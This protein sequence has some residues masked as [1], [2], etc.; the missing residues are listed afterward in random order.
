[1]F[2]GDPSHL[3][4][5][6]LAI[7]D[8]ECRWLERL[9]AAR[10]AEETRRAASGRRGAEALRD[11]LRALRD[12]AMERS[13][14]DLPDVLH[15]LSVRQRLAAQPAQALPDQSV[16][17]L[18]HLAVMQAGRR[19][20]Y[21]LGQ[22]SLFDAERDV[23]MVDWRVAPVAQI[24]YGYKEGEQYEVEYPGRSVE[25]VVAVRRAVVVSQ[26]VLR[27][28]LTEGV[29]L[30]RTEQGAWLREDRDATK[31]ARGGAGNAARPGI[32]GVGVGG[33]HRADVA[34]TALLDAEQYAVVSAA[35]D[36]P[37]LVLGSAGSGKTTV[38]LHRLMW[39]AT[40]KPKRYA[41]ERALVI[42][43]EEGLARLSR[44]LLQP[45]GGKTADVRTL[46]AW[47]EQ[48]CKDV[49]GKSMPP[50]Y[51]DAPG[52]VVNLKR[53]PA[54]YEELRVEFAK[55]RPE[56]TTIRRLR[57]RLVERFSDRA[58]LERVVAR[59][60]GTLA[61]AAIEQ[62]VRH[63]MLQIADT[64]AAE[65]ARITDPRMKVALDGERIEAGTPQEIA[66]TV[67]I[68]DLPIYLFLKAWR[69]K[70]SVA[71]VSQLVIDEA[72]D[73]SLFELF[74]LGRLL[75][76]EA[77]VILAGDEAQQTHSSFVTWQRA[78][79][80]LGSRDARICRLSTSYRCPRPIAE[81]AQHIL[82]PLANSE[83]PRVARDGAPVGYFQFEQASQVELF[84][85]QA[86]TELLRNE[87]EASAAI[88]LGNRTR[89]A[90]FRALFRD[91]PDVRGVY[92]GEF[93]F[94]PGLDVTHLDAIKGLE[95]D[96]VL[97]PDATASEYP[98]TEDSRRRLHVAVTRAAHQ[99]WLVAAAP[100]TG[101]VTW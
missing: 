34:V 92:D 29:T 99:L 59:A 20:D 76:D 17:Y 8:E 7:V 75:E 13:E 64:A 2:T 46:D 30:R 54:L 12:D 55:L 73:F 31:L 42:V 48:L 71:R 5:E 70:L 65:L 80:A 67:D 58:F 1:M 35:Q 26:G 89:V 45:L 93:S 86:M 56:H 9:L 14:D 21:L 84:V 60:D 95:F 16:P 74:V 47:A 51:R 72:E 68:E 100:G 23:R 6:E 15:E 24:Y 44:R 22:V 27:A 41:L 83:P 87:P 96:Y 50:I 90:E 52:L 98:A 4:E 37:V 49:F 39:L 88:V 81:V 25:G 79:E 57:R 11:E 78:L 101:L 94:N 18:A 77:S 3:T 28:I 40:V 91:H 33:A 63:T 53:H 97:V 10:A 62:T 38:A 69:D 85:V 43:P 32:L 82:G 19:R 36:D 66:G 61:R